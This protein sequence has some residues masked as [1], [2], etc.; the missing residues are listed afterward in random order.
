MLTFFVFSGSCEGLVSRGNSF[1]LDLVHAPLEDAFPSEDKVKV[2]RWKVGGVEVFFVVK[3]KFASTAFDKRVCFQDFEDGPKK[4][5]YKAKRTS[6]ETYKSF[7][8]GGREFIVHAKIDQ[9][10]TPLLEV[11]FMPAN[12]QQM[13]HTKGKY[14][15]PDV[16][17][18]F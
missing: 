6:A 8:D 16:K 11:D 15:G 12:V 3:K 9:T 5:Y 2:Y 14:S 7:G 4:L 18:N 17:S 13:A 10:C 1:S